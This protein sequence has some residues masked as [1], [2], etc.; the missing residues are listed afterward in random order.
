[1]P[2]LDVYDAI[3]VGARC[4]GAPTAMHLARRGRRVLLLDRATFPSD[5][6]STHYVSQAGVVYLNQWGLLEEIQASN[7]PPIT[8]MTSDWGDF[9]LV[10]R[11]PPV[12]GAPAAY[13]PR[14]SVLDRILIEA[15]LRA[16]AELRERVTLED[17]LW[18]D[19]RV[20]GVRARA[21]GGRSHVE[22]ARVVV[23]ADGRNSTVA[24]LVGAPKYDD[25]PP[26]ACQWF[27]YWGGFSTEGLES[28][29]RGRVMLFGI[30]TNDGLTCVVT[31][32]PRERFEA[33]RA[34]APG[35]YMRLIDLAPG[36]AARVRAGRREGPLFGTGDLPNFFRRSYGPGWALVGDAGNH[37]DPLTAQGIRDAFCD[38]ERLAAAIDDGL[39]GRA[40]LEE[41]LAEYERGRDER[42]R[43][44]Y[45]H[46][47]KVARLPEPTE[48]DYRFRAALRGR[49]PDIDRYFGVGDGTVSP[50]EFFGPENTR[51]LLA[52]AGTPADAPAP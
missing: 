34:D 5:T 36:L 49:Q 19:G 41:A 23:G 35:N 45:D 14:R 22:R 25:T 20:V 31:A 3:V 16:G 2:G 46:T 12:E 15:A 32:M 51:R 40:P 18:E 9:T 13:A 6:L 43:E 37:K 21:G 1:L 17:L 52:A 10:G 42:V 48:D 27:A 44:L 28:Y 8:R 4:A 11:P 24:R 30:P 26:L 33:F 47:C 50:L 38:A 39:N 7:C 29:R